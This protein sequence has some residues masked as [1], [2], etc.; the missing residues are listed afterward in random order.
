MQ[1][2][3][4]DGDPLAGVGSEL[5]QF[6]LFICAATFVLWCIREGFG[7]LTERIQRGW[8]RLNHPKPKPRPQP[9][10]DPQKAE[11]A[12][13]TP[14]PI[15]EPEPPP[16]GVLVGTD[17]ETN[18]PLYIPQELRRRH[19]YLIGKTGTGKTV[20]SSYGRECKK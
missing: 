15:E 16:D 11:T 7:W 12:D 9:Q 17:T 20:L 3:F 13:L 4:S 14:T 8:Y 6:F 5:F 1:S 2:Y 18:K 10:I 19:L